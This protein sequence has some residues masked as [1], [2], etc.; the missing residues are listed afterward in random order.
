MQFGALS[1]LAQA[2]AYGE[3]PR[4]RRA[5][6]RRQKMPVWRAKRREAERI[7]TTLV[8]GPV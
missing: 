7:A 1:L 4:R 6:K 8:V 3:V 5:H 2:F